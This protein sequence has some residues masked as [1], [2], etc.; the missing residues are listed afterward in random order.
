[1]PDRENPRFFLP[2]INRGGRVGYNKNRDVAVDIEKG[3]LMIAMLAG[4]V[5]I[6]PGL[7]RIIYSFHLAAF[8][9]LSG[10]F[11]RKGRGLK[12]T[13]RGLFR[14][15]LIP[16]GIFCAVHFAISWTGNPEH[17][18]LYYMKQY[19]FGM[20]FSENLWQDVPSVGPVYFILL[21]LLVWLFYYGTDQALCYAAKKEGRN[22][23]MGGCVISD[24]RSH[25]TFCCRNV[26]WEGRMVAAMERGCRPILR[27]ILLGR[28][29]IKRISYTGTMQQ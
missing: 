23:E 11:Y 13:L 18:A 14:T 29:S 6:N 15:F 25:R 3:I 20:S 26:S 7:R 17:G 19:L 21:L 4:H 2:Y 27:F 9:V 1:M 5:T 22:R 8:V 28:H 24:A 10:Y 12:N 16:Y